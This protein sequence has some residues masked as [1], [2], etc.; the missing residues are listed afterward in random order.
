MTRVP[1]SP[2]PESLVDKVYARAE[3]LFAESS[4]CSAERA[5]VLMGGLRSS[6]IDVDALLK[7]FEDAEE[8]GYEDS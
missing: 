4:G 3:Q 6:T 2:E 8:A 5:A 7:S 1:D